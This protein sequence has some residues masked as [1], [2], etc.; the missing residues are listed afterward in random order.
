[1]PE[2]TALPRLV[3]WFD[4]GQTTGCAVL[5]TGHG[6][7]T[8]RSAQ[9]RTE[10]IVDEFQ[11]LLDMYE[12]PAGHRAWV[13]WENYI[14]TAG[15]GMSGTPRHALEAIGVIR[16]VCDRYKVRH[17]A[18]VPSSA[19]KVVSAAV[20]REIGWYQ[21]G[22]V[23]ANDAAQHLAAWC[24]REGHLTQLLRPAL[25]RSLPI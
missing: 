4:P 24:L 18:S 9:W 25:R 17:L 12:I 6:F 7:N 2:P 20:L 22:Q 13:G 15:G 3:V 19:R 21:P 8:F 11:D 10:E 1:M 14:V 16:G 23:H 5:A